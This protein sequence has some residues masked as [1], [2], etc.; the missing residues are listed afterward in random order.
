MT[1]YNSY[2]SAES[3]HFTIKKSSP[4]W[5]VG[6]KHKCEKCI[7]DDGEDSDERGE[8]PDQVDLHFH[9]LGALERRG[10]VDIFACRLGGLTM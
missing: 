10:F 6:Q 1:S 7:E 8:H 4:Y 9:M 5:W 2:L 3:Q